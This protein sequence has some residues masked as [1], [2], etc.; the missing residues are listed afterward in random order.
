[1]KQTDSCWKDRWVGEWDERRDGDKPKDIY[2]Q[3]MDMTAIEE[4][5]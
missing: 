4:L 1:M 5:I 3:P 2:T